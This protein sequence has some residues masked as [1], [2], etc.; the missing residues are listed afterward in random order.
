MNYYPDYGLCYQTVTLYLRR[1]DGVIRQVVRN[2]SFIYG[3][4]QVKDH[5]G[6]RQE[7]AF[8][9]IIPGN[10]DLAPGDRV[11]DGIGP[12][13]VDWDTFL[14]V[15]VPGLAEVEYVQHCAWRNLLC[16]TRAGRR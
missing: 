4:Q 11:Y 13:S 6:T 14:P 12:E 3:V 15:S 2:A 16:H 7:T 5:L 9:L 10:V 8:Q 1:E